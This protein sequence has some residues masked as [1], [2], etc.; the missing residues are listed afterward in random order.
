MSKL[1]YFNDNSNAK[2]V[3]PMQSFR[4]LYPRSD[5]TLEMY[6]TPMAENGYAPGRDNDVYV[7]TIGTNKHKEVM[8]AIGE[9][10]INGEDPLLTI[11]NTA[12]SEFI[13]SEVSSFTV[14]LS[15]DP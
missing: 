11:V 4:G 8:F 6:F 15:S 2:Y 9:A 5:T 1:I 3:Y 14:T 7:L 12:T 10:M 13:H